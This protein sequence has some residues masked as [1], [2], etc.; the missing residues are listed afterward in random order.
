MDFDE[1]KKNENRWKTWKVTYGWL[2]VNVENALERKWNVV[3]SRWKC[4]NFSSTSEL[5]SPSGSVSESE[6]KENYSII[7]TSR[8][9]RKG[10]HFYQRLMPKRKPS[11][12]DLSPDPSPSLFCCPLFSK[13]TS[14]S[15][16]SFSLLS[17]CP[18]SFAVFFLSLFP[19]CAPPPYFTVLLSC[20]CH[21][22]A[23]VLGTS[24][25]S[26][27]LLLRVALWDVGTIIVRNLSPVKWLHWS[28]MFRK[29][30]VVWFQL[31][32]MSWKGKSIEMLV[33]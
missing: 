3:S 8:N 24:Y 15:L 12:R 27:H 11:S 1:R 9:K 29:W 6:Y 26:W 5:E 22:P 19:L 28:Y 25:E 30:S 20:I 18:F 23:K 13:S 21:V 17:S 7:I 2:T 4:V 10:S 32:D 31:D 16:L 14:L 33:E